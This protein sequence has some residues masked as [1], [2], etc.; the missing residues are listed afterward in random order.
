MNQNS[1]FC[2][3]NPSDFERDKYQNTKKEIVWTNLGPFSDVNATNNQE[4]NIGRIMSL[5]IASNHQTFWIASDGGGLWKSENAGMSWLD[6]GDKLPTMNLS[7]ATISP[8]NNNIIYVAN[9]N[10]SQYENNKIFKST[11]KGEIFI[12]IN[13]DDVSLARKISVHPKNPDT[14]LI[15]GS[16]GIYFSGNGGYDFSKV[17]SQSDYN[18]TFCD[19]LYHPTNPDICYVSSNQC[20]YKSTNRGVSFTKILDITSSRPTVM[21]VTPTSPDLIW[22]LCTNTTYDSHLYKSTN[23]GTNFTKQDLNKNLI[24]MLEYRNRALAI[25]PSISDRYYAGGVSLYRWNGNKYYPVPKVHADISEMTFINDTL[26][27]V[28]DGGISR[29]IDR[30][31][32]DDIP[33]GQ[34][35][36]SLNNN[37]PIKQIYKMQVTKGNQESIIYGSQDNGTS[38]YKDNSWCWVADGDGGD[39]AINPQNPDQY[40]YTICVVKGIMSNDGSYDKDLFSAGE[41][42]NTGFIFPVELD[43]SN[44]QILYYAGQQLFQK[45]HSDSSWNAITN[46]DW[47]TSSNY[48]TYI[49]FVKVAP[50]N[51]N[52]IYIVNNMTVKSTFSN[53]TVIYRSLN[54]G[55]DWI[56]LNL[57]NNVLQIADIA[58]NPNQANQLCII[59]RGD[60]KVYESSDYG[61]NWTEITTGF[62]SNP[63]Y[64]LC[65]D[66]LNHNGKYIASLGQVYYSDSTLTSSINFTGNLPNVQITDIEINPTLQKLYISTYGRGIFK[67]D[68]YIKKPSL[69]TIT[70]TAGANGSIIPSGII[71]VESG[72][73]T[74]FTIIPNSNY[75][76]SNL[77][78]DNIKISDTTTYT[79]YNISKNHTIDVDFESI[80][81]ITENDINKLNVYSNYNSIY[82]INEK[83]INIDNIEIVNIYGQTIWQQTDSKSP[84]VLNV[85][86]GIY[87][88]K[89][90]SKKNQLKN[91]KLIIKK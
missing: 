65:Y 50:S 7:Y 87:F 88:V 80:D 32:Y 37:L 61:E 20:F 35:F 8:S 54:Q 17:I 26:Y 18:E 13:T 3:Q 33:Y 86:D 9:N 64:A 39:C 81:K 42:A 14:V 19:I 10:T 82:I 79:F 23:A 72:H 69:Y 49:D 75:M 85:A 76:I 89:L 36:S 22:I 29:I 21:A 70:A 40:Y 38:L 62:G 12:E 28:S 27:I 47:N 16:K 46:F 2:R 63:L 15:C 57:P 74:T 25:H 52:I 77:M 90:Y 83:N 66:G 67:T 56:Q 4:A 5:S 30:L 45:K 24:G 53:S 71:T 31:E 44:P 51:S 59:S 68:M 43:A 11:T 91:F 6:Y 78:I 60:Y 48:Y 55:K 73:D 41:E 58:V 1:N 34:P 84:I